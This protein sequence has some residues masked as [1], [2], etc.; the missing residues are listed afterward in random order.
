MSVPLSLVVIAAGCLL[1]VL[2]SLRVVRSHQGRFIA[3]PRAPSGLGSRSTPRDRRTSGLS[4]AG[5]F[6]AAL[7]GA[8][9][10]RHIGWWAVAVAY[11]ALFL[12]MLVPTLIHDRN[13]RRNCQP[14]ALDPQL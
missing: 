4:F 9:L 13:V 10:E 3:K 8:S 11:L 14:E 12:I 6:V 7:G 1:G 5:I 2:E